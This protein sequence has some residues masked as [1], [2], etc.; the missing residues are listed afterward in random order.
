MF[1]DNVFE[2]VLHSPMSGFDDLKLKSF[3]TMCV[4]FMHP[5]LKLVTYDSSL[6]TILVQGTAH[7]GSS[8]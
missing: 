8:I 4:L 3:I 5:V 1:S 6:Q 7:P 2:F